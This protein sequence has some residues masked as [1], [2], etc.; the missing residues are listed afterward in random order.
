ML[1]L[2]SKEWKLVADA[3]YNSLMENNTWEL[4]KLPEGRKV[5]GSK[6]VFRVKYDGKE[7]SIGSRVDLPHKDT[8]RSM[9]SITM[10]PSL[11]SHGSLQFALYLHLLCKEEC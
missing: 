1:T 3:E 9:V 8:H 7:E 6:W 11:L 5:I 4:V 10:K 2:F